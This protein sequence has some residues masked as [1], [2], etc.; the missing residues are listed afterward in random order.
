MSPPLCENQ[1]V[2]REAGFD[3]LW[4]GAVP[5]S[6]DGKGRVVACSYWIVEATPN[7]PV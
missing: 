4:F 1:G 6:E 2:R 7:R 5:D 3:N